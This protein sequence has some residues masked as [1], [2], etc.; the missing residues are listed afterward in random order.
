MTTLIQLNTELQVLDLTGNESIFFPQGKIPGAATSGAGDQ[1]MSEMSPVLK[2]NDK[3]SSRSLPWVPTDEEEQEFDAVE[4]YI[5]EEEQKEEKCNDEEQIR[6]E[7]ALTHFFRSLQTNS[8]LMEL[9]LNYCGIDDAEFNFL[10]C[11]LERNRKLSVLNLNYNHITRE[12]G[13]G[14]HL[15]HA[16]PVLSTL[17]QLSLKG[18]VRETKPRHHNHN[19]MTENAD[20]HN[21]HQPQKHHSPHINDYHHHHSLSSSDQMFLDALNENSVLVCLV[22]DEDTF[23]HHQH[24]HGPVDEKVQTNEFMFEKIK[25]LLTRNQEWQHDLKMELQQRKAAYAYSRLSTHLDGKTRRKDTKNSNT[26]A[27]SNLGMGSSRRI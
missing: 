9:H 6:Y 23:I 14:E 2:Q 26:T 20:Y 27:M 1:R 7:N 25:Q 16:L 21:H 13:L 11:A 12:V 8:T 10:L 22:L 3:F 17:S 18:L 15:V 24:R 19:A 4:H 5:D